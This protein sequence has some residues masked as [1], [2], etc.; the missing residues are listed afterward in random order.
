MTREFVSSAPAP[1]G[2]FRL[3]VFGESQPLLDTSDAGSRPD[4]EAARGASRLYE[5][6]WT[7]ASTDANE[8]TASEAWAGPAEAG[9]H[10]IGHGRIG[11]ARGREDSQERGVYAHVTLWFPTAHGWWVRDRAAGVRHLAPLPP[12]FRERLADDWRV[13]GPLLDGAGKVADAAAPFAGPVA[14][15]AGKTLAAL[16]QI[17]VS[18]VPASD[19]SWW[20]T[21]TAAARDGEFH[22]GVT[23]TL[24]RNLRKRLGPRISG[25]IIVSVI[26]MNAQRADA[27]AAAPASPASEGALVAEA[28]VYDDSGTPQTIGPL[29]LRI[30]P[31]TPSDV[32]GS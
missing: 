32:D 3:L 27:G 22:E 31:V 14:T 26:P 8:P 4:E 23:W 30:T 11:G 18:S 7:L 13:I 12:D 20:V 21:S 10:S 5:Y 17:K 6:G 9:G 2:P 15:E 19:L 1:D 24:T 16:G 29:K 25:G 28:T